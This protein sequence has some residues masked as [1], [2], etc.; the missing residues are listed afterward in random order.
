[1]MAKIL[2]LQ[3][4][5]GLSDERV[6]EELRLNLAYMWFIGINPGDDLPHPSLLSKFRTM[7]L[8][9]V[10]LDDILTEVVRQCVDKKIIPAECETIVDVTHL[11]ADTTKKVPERIMKHLARKIFKAMGQ[12]EYEIPDYTQI[13]DHN[14]AKEMMKGF[15]E[16]TM[17]GAD[18][19]A[20]EEVEFAKEVLESPLFMEQKGIRSLTDM[21]ARVGYKTK[22]D[23]FFGYKMEYAMT[24]EGLIT[25][26]S[27]HDGAYADGTDF[28]TLFGNMSKA[29]LDIKAF[30][31][32]KAY[33]R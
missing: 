29:G 31:A 8:K 25:A 1:M 19:R 20:K 23:S 4:L 9:D 21:D 3:P 5:Y 16:E 26:V 33:F 10:S 6:I 24:T 22:T 32:D 13:K 18:E 14:E 11:L 15:L 17:E 12:K 28:I 27:V 7:R 2:I 30:F